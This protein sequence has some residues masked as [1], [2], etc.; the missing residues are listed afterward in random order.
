MYRKRIRNENG[1]ACDYYYYFS[2]LVQNTNNYC[3]Y[4]RLKVITNQMNR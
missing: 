4:L 3:T 1:M 2:F